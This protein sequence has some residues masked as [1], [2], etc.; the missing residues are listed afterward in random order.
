V[1]RQSPAFTQAD[2]ARAIKGARAAGMNVVRVEVMQ[3]G[4][5]V[6]AAPTPTPT[7]EPANA[8]DQWMQEHDHA[9]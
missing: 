2:V 5:I 4:R 3:D 6:L 8:L 7:P 9:G 1:P